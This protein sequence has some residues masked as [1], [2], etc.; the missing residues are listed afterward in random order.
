MIVSNNIGLLSPNTNILSNGLERKISI[1]NQNFVNL[2][3]IKI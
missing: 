3:K 1:K 2:G